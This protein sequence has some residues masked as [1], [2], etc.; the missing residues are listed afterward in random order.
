MIMNIRRRSVIAAGVAAP[1]LLPTM[2]FARAS[3]IFMDEGGLFS[4][5][6]THA[7]GGHDVVAY[8]SLPAEAAPVAGD[9]GFSTSYKDV[10]WLF[11]DADNR[12]AFNADPDKYRPAYGGYCAWAMARGKLAKGEPE[13]WHVYNGVLYLNVSKRIKKDWLS[14]IDR[15]IE[16]ANA[17]W[18]G[19]LEKF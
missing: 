17:N 5:E 13:V 3:E 6:W 2:A 16:R 10:D 18:P 15:D 7:V 8:H 11:S 12:E 14:N 19:V 4:S 9:A 1:V